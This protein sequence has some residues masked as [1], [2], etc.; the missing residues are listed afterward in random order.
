M[1]EGKDIEGDFD[2]DEKIACMIMSEEVEEKETTKLFDIKMCIGI[3]S[4]P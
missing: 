1:E 3:V 4:T 2:M